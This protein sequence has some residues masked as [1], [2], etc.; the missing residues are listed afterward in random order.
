VALNDLI[1]LGPA[2]F[3]APEHAL[4]LTVDGTDP[5]VSLPFFAFRFHVVELALP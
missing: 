5:D 4:R 3:A 2:E 1:D